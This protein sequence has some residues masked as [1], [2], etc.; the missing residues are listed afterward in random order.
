LSAY[1]LDT[2]VVSALLRNH[3]EVVPKLTEVT[4]AGD[5]VTLTAISYFEA[6]RGLLLPHLANKLRVFERFARVYGVL[7]LT[8]ST[9]DLAADIYQEL[10]RRGELIEDADIL[11]AA[12]ALA[13]DAVLVT[14]NLK[15]FERVEGLRLESWEA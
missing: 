7:P 8:T 11:I 15:H 10:R 1:V 3:A 13:H 5:G 6:R 2:N 14:R 12:T 4:V 9:L